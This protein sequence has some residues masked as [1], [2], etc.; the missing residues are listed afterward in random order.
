MITVPDA[1]A[2]L[3]LVFLGIVL[4]VIWVKSLVSYD[5]K[6]HNEE[7]IEWP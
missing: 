7:E 4:N 2:N 5:P 1:I 6:D 3:A